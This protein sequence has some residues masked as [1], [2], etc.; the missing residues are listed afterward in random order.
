M[1]LTEW[2][3]F[4]ESEKETTVDSTLN[5][6]HEEGALVRY[7]LYTG[8]ILLTS[9]PTRTFREIPGSITIRRNE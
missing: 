2:P 5:S 6:K 8:I 1:L 7:C 4:N 3:A 9:K